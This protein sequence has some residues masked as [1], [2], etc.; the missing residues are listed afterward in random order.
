M[1]WLDGTRELKTAIRR[2]LER[3]NG[4]AY[5]LDQIVVSCGAKQ[6][7]FNLCLA[8]LEADEEAIV[9]A[10]YWVSYPEMVR[11]TDAEPVFVYCIPQWR[12]SR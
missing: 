8:L 6:A 5:S 1:R 10:P 9:P 4:L 3:E 12:L 7:C 2:K 11:I